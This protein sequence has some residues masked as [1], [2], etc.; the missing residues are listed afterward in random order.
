[1]RAQSFLGVVLLALCVHSGCI[2]DSG[3]EPDIRGTG[4][5]RFIGIEGGFYGII[6]DD[7]RRYDPMHLDKAFQ[8]DG[9]K[10]RFEGNIRDDLASFH[11]WGVLIE[12]TKIERL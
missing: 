1:M 9:L 8:E 6:A 5:V 11:M 12:L 7:G 2:F 10:V 4:T 3:P